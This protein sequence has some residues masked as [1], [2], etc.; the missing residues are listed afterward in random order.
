MESTPGWRPSPRALSAGRVYGAEVPVRVTR[1]SLPFAGRGGILLSPVG[2]TLLGLA[3]LA[4]YLTFRTMLATHGAAAELNPLA[5]SLQAHGLLFALV[6][7]LAVWA[8]VAA[9]VA[10][11][12]RPRPGLARFVLVFGILVGVVGALSNLATI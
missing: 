4:D 1:S 8:L 10:V 3:Q 7:K 6:A 2:V 5:V 11:L 9:V 12:V